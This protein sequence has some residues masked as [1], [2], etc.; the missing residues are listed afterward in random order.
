MSSGPEKE[1]IFVVGFRSPCRLERDESAGVSTKD[2]MEEE[3]VD[4]EGNGE[5]V[6]RGPCLL[7][8]WRP[9]FPFPPFSATPPQAGRPQKWEP[10]NYRKHSSRPTPP[11]LLHRG[12]SFP[13]RPS[14]R[15]GPPKASFHFPPPRT[16]GRPP[17]RTG[18]VRRERTE[19]R[20]GPAN[21][22]LEGSGGWG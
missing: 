22:V 4:L 20:K 21:V 2:A 6:G 15:T 5:R 13:T 18:G 9:L 12:Q 3:A 10:S 16:A 19:R 17:H 1:R 8:E 11:A 7:V 14:N